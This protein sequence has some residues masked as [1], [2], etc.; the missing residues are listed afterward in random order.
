[1]KKFLFIGFVSF[2][3]FFNT[4][5]AVDYRK[6]VDDYSINEVFSS[7]VLANEKKD[8]VIKKLEEIRK[9]VLKTGGFY[10][11]DVKVNPVLSDDKVTKVFNSFDEYKSN[12]SLYD[13]YKNVFF[14]IKLSE[15]FKDRDS[16]DK[17][18]SFLK[19]EF[20]DFSYEVSNDY[21]YSLKSIDV[22]K[23]TLKDAEDVVNDFKSKYEEVTGGI[24][25]VRNKS[26]DEVIISNEIKDSFDNYDDALRLKNSL[27]SN[28]EYEISSDISKESREVE[29]SREDVSKVFKSLKEAEDYISDLKSKGYDV[30]GLKTELQSFMESVWSVDS[31]VIVNPGTVDGKVFNYG[32]FDI[33]LVND[34]VKIDKDGNESN[35]RGNIVINKVVVNNGDNSKNI[36]MNN[37]SR[38]P[39][40]GY[41]EY[42]SEKR[43]GL[44]IT[45]KSLVTIS[46]NV[47]YNGISLPFTISGYLSE[48]CNVC[49]GRG[50]SKGFDLKFKSVTIKDDKVII[51]TKLVNNYKVSGTIFKKENKDFYVVRYT[52][53]KKGYDYKVSLKGK[54]RSLVYVLNG[55]INI[56][57]KVYDYVLSGYGRG[58]MLYGDVLVKYVDRDGKEIAKNDYFYDRVNNS[59]STKPKDLKSKGYVYSGLYSVSKDDYDTY[60]KFINDRI[61]ITYIYDKDNVHAVQTGVSVNNGYLIP[62][63]VSSL[64]LVLLVYFKRRFS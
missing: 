42:T 9:N 28:D 58:Y 36:K 1:M 14:T 7:E 47:L 52:K 64:G 53:T 23:K 34:F 38:D 3:A 17:R 16:L 10:S 61:V 57:R 5:Y 55:N 26:L 33:V 49:G 30:S 11:Y 24:T 51:D 39:N 45:N 8:N 19:D 44:N 43:Q 20:D 21:E 2:F 60:G 35:V 12:F 13:D 6:N 46:G 15:R 32:H 18:I 31:S 4:T 41:Y 56:E 54:E 25:K 37:P 59:Y 62:L 40:G 29:T 48:S 22:V 50:S 63:G 27:V